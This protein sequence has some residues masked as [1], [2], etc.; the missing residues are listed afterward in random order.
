MTAQA[1][2]ARL[3]TAAA[4]FRDAIARA[5]LRPPSAIIPDGG[6]HRFSTNGK[7][8]DDA[9]WYVFFSD[10]VPAGAFGCW[11]TGIQ[12]HWSARSDRHMTAAERAVYQRRI[13][14]LQQQRRDE[15]ARRHAEAAEQASALWRL[16]E[17][18]PADHPYLVRKGV[19]PHGLRLYRGALVIAGQSINGF[20]IV[21][22]HD[23]DG[24]LCSLEFISA[25]G[26][27]FFLPGGRKRGASFLI[28]TIHDVLCIAE[29]FATG[30]SIY[31]ATGCACAVAFDAGNLKA[32]AEAYRSAYPTVPLIICGD[33]DANGVGQAK[34]QE[35]AVAVGARIA[36]PETPGCDWNDIAQRFGIQTVKEGVMRAVNDPGAQDETR[37]VAVNGG[38]PHPAVA[39]E[40]LAPDWPTLD[41][42]A[43]HGLAGDVVRA[44]SPHTEADDA[45]LLLQLLAF[46]GNVIGRHAHALVE[47]DRHA[48][49][50]FVVLVGETAKARKGTSAGL[51]RRLFDSVDPEWTSERIQSGLASGEGLLWA[52]RDPISKT[53][54]IRENG[55]PTGETRDIV[56]DRGVGDKRLLVLEPE[57]GRVLAVASR[58]G[59]TLSACL[60]Q[61]WDTGH[62]RVLTRNLPVYAT[63][64]HISLVGHVTRDELVRLLTETDAAGGT[65]NRVLWAAVRR[66]K[67]LPD[68]GHPDWAALT[69]IVDRIGQAVAFARQAGELR[70]DAEAR[71]LWRAVYPSISAEKPGLLGAVVARAEAQVLRLSCLYALL[72]QSTT[73]R[74][75]HL[76]AALATWQYCERSAEFIFGDR[77]GDPVAD[78]LLAAL[79]RA[80]DGLSRT[81][82]RDLFGRHRRSH[83]IERALGVLARQGLAR[84]ERVQTAGRPTDVWKA[85][86]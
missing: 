11:R 8:D 2:R 27:K 16:S 29:G 12:Q 28:G 83:E 41:P 31:E 24:R 13:E 17:P 14:Q 49:N 34:S 23:T 36:I 80:P 86:R 7:P 67:L 56:I 46:V 51:I 42:A 19:Q 18:A 75:P 15:E 77:L 62:L 48:M 35:A 43:L 26:D 20:L 37:A 81:E 45:A 54:A 39:G 72:D 22:L 58:E 55:A 63:G 82:I 5:G 85:V 44:L 65:Y 25:D 59:S 84:P 3:D 40:P 52:V 66:S 4:E 74:A 76:E 6:I 57:F 64:A 79:R 9:G 73:V 61:A 32:V 10:S 60:R 70:R 30:A 69:R 50:L 1:F 71:E 21:P 38:W 47:G 53:E 68:G 33:H 78:D